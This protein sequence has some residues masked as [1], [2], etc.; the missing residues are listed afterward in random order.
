MKDKL[1][2]AGILKSQ[3]RCQHPPRRLINAAP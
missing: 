2:R 1:M 3:G